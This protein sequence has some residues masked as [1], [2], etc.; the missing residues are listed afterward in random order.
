MV[1]QEQVI[2]VP[3]LRLVRLVND[4]YGS[5]TTLIITTTTNL[6]VLSLIRVVVCIAT[7]AW[8]NYGPF[9]NTNRSG[10]ARAVA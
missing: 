1:R 10:I 5:M 7:R 3:L 4:A 6:V 2:P 9:T 8:P